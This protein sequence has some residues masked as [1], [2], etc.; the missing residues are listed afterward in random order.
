[1]KLSG[2]YWQ[3]D[4]IE[5]YGDTPSDSPLS[6]FGS[7]TLVLNYAQGFNFYN[8]QLGYSLKYTYMN[9]LEYEDKRMNKYLEYYLHM[10]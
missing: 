5:M 8:H 10:V 1:M 2:F 7:K 6:T 3:V 4:D 9:L